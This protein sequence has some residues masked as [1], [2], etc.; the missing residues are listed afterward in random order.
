MSLCV[1]LAENLQTKQAIKK[2]P[3]LKKHK[4][5]SLFREGKFINKGFILK[6]N[7][8]AYIK[9]RLSLLFVWQ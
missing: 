4:T 7:G 8:H 6:K 5:F 9:R 1:Q 2:R 3:N